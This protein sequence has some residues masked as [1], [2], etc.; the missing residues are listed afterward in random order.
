MT[1]KNIQERRKIVRDYI[2]KNPGCTYLDIRKNT[3]IKAERIYKNMGEAYCDAS[4]ELSKNLT[5]RKKEEQKQ[6][7]LQFI[8]NN[9]TSTV[10]EIQNKTKVNVP[11][12]F[13]SIMAAYEAAGMPYIDREVT[14]GV[15]NPRVIKRCN[16]F[17]KKH[18]QTVR[19]FRGEN[20]VTMHE[21]KQLIKYMKALHYNHGLL[22]CPEESFPKRK[23]RRLRNI[24][25]QPKQRGFL[26]SQIEEIFI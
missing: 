20:N 23:N 21:I 4:L 19:K 3:K 8:R 15:V 17:E 9:P 11:R 16:K 12:L 24:L 14:W 5:K 13:G 25:W 7:I 26:L 2:S 10:T 1:Y 22:I 6:A 18:H